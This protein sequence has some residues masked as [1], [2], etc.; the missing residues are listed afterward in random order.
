MRRVPSRTQIRGL[1]TLLLYLRVSPV[2]RTGSE[3]MT[4]V[5]LILILGRENQVKSADQC[6]L[7]TGLDFV[8]W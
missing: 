3:T 7:F 1:K 5:V 6:G 4:L 2:Q 8:K